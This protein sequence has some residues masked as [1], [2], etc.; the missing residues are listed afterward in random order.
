MQ[1]LYKFELCDTHHHK[2]QISYHQFPQSSHKVKLSSP[3]LAVE[4][5]IQKWWINLLK[6]IFLVRSR[7]ESK[8]KHT[9]IQMHHPEV[10]ND[11]ETGDM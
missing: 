10:V 8:L 11:A 6:T 5:A 3:L 7:P 2:L 1:S 9:W 4:T